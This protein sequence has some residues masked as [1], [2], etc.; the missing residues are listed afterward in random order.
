[1]KG[2]LDI[3][4][5][6]RRRGL[7]PI[8]I[9]PRDKRPLVSWEEFQKAPADQAQLQQWGKEFQGA[10]V[11]IV[12]G[13]VSDIVVI[14]IDSDPA[15]EKLKTLLGNYAID[16]V[17]RSRTGKGWQLFFKHPGTPIQNRT[18][19]F[20]GLDVRGDGGYVVAPPSIHP[21]GKPYHWEVPLRDELPKLPVELLKLITQSPEQHYRARFN[22][23]EALNGVPEG[24]RDE[25]VFKLA[26]KLRS[27][28][29]PQEMAAQLVIEA[30]K[31][32]EPPFHETIALEKVARAYAKYRPKGNGAKEPEFWPTFLTAKDILQAPADPTRWLWENCLPLGGC[33]IL[34]SKPKLGKSTL[35]ANLEIAI[36]RG[37]P[38]LNRATQ[39]A[40]V[41]YV[42]LDAS[43]PEMA[44]VFVKFGLKESD[45]IFLHAG[46]APKDCV[47]WIMQRVK[48]NGVKLVVIDTIQR[49]FK[50]RD[51][52]D[53]S[54]VVN[55]MDPLLE[56][57]REGNIHLLFTHHA[58]KDTADDL[59]AAIGSTAIRG[60]AY[61]YLHLKR[62]PNSERR[63]FRSD[64][65]GGKNF[66]ETA[67]R[68]SSSNG[69]LEVCGSMEEA[70]IEEAEPLVIE[71][72]RAE[73]G[74]VPEKTIRENLNLRA[75]IIS[76]ALRKLFR[77][78]DVDRIG[79]GR[80]GSPFRYSVVAILDDSLPGERVLGR[81]DTGIES[82]K[83][84]KDVANTEEILFPN[85]SEQ[86]GN[87]TEQNP[88]ARG[89]GTELENLLKDGWE[90]I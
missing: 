9:K 33:S 27:A 4:I 49:L 62:L 7:S 79:K 1:V 54:Q 69:W 6:Y 71:F 42:S 43:L 18:G 45:P 90:V 76:K 32:C 50:F 38:F 61:T 65:R 78:G 34:V 59:D 84:G 19:V 75:F 40:G 39:Q 66:P 29:V 48:E 10:N 53:Y 36:A 11:G 56:A 13:A 23:V 35:A 24:Q 5:E 28:D 2:F 57:A 74:D 51:V 64:Q 17:P 58:R 20:P 82:P 16:E 22:T 52:N 70:E 83:G 25:T 44:D 72:L 47:G 89:A 15:K 63:I 8:P 30:A 37:V 86:N 3:V 21:N 80:K 85:V 31:N 41:A 68:F 60:L 46:T 87:R 88:K 14:D 12:T 67:I 26:C 77:Q 55:A 81:E 73:G